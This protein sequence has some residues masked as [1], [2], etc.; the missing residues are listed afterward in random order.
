MATR[1]MLDMTC[2]EWFDLYRV[3]LPELWKMIQENDDAKSFEKSIAEWLK[4]QLETNSFLQSQ[5]EAADCLLEL[6]AQSETPCLECSEDELIECKTLRQLWSGI[7]EE[8]HANHPDFYHE[9]Y[10]LFMQLKGQE[11]FSPFSADDV[12]LAIDRWPSGLDKEVI[13]IRDKNKARMIELLVEDL[14]AGSASAP[15]GRFRLNKDL[16]HE[17][18]KH[19]VEQWWHD[20]RFQLAMAI[21]DPEKLNRYLGNT[22]PDAVMQRLRLAFEKEIPFFVTP[23]YLSL[24]NTTESGYDD[25]TIRDYIIYSDELIRNFGSIKAWEREDKINPEEGNAAGWLLPDASSVHRRYPEVAILIPDTMGR[26]CG[27]LCAS[28]QRM[29]GFQ[30]GNLNF[31]LDT[32]KPQA[33][34]LEKLGACLTYFENDSQLRDILITGGDALMSQNKT[35]RILLQ[36][37]LKMAIRKRE[38]NQYRA[39]GEKYAELQRVRLGTRLPAYLPFRITDELIGILREFREEGLK[40]GITQF[41]IQTHF[42]SPLEVTPEAVRGIRL[43]LSAGWVITNQLVFTVP[44]S[45]RGHTA[46]LRQVLNENGVIGYYTFTVKGFEENEHLFVPNS[47]SVQEQL[48]EKSYGVLPE[49]AIKELLHILDSPK[50][51]REAI[52]EL[53]NAY[54]LPFI[55]TDRSV[56][57]LPGVGKSMSYRLAGFDQDGRRILAF[58]HDATRR[59]SPVIEHFPEVFIRE[60]KSLGAY[61]RQLRAMGE[62]TDTY[63]SIW[64]YRTAA[65]EPRFRFYE[66]PSQPHPVT[67][68]ITNLA[69]SEHFY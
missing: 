35:L 20:H 61:L 58:S 11:G 36:E 57:N 60:R 69:V 3:E 13:A 66:Y 55:A 2:A 48:E 19:C 68:K 45:R 62:D 64:K 1:N 54:N 24:L 38:T 27:G 37:V 21:R 14:S 40:A 26:A 39:D 43:L 32:L 47:R 44:A 7:R 51:L 63:E 17:Q 10:R 25:R 50:S 46:K 29:Y 49:A 16:T 8:G 42:Q 15:P 52:P 53:T 67:A 65:T 4:K 12:R 56:M 31:D 28:C 22:L 59:H 30:K 5:H 23:Y 34:W 6:I 41:V 33:G 9:I 18:K